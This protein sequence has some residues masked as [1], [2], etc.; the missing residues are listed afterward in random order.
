MRITRGA[1]DFFKQAC[2]DVL[3]TM[4]VGGIGVAVSEESGQKQEPVLY[5][6]LSLPPGTVKQLADE[7]MPLL[8]RRKGPLLVNDLSHDKTF[9]WLAAHCK[10]VL[11]V[12]M[13]RAEQVLGCFFACDK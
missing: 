10:Q 2:L 6:R 5:G 11:A 1:S 3:E 8:A 12:P 4:G 9:G 13:L 7:L